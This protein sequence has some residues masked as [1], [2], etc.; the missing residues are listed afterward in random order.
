M[1]KV[2]MMSREMHSLL[3]VAVLL[4][5]QNRFILALPHGTICDD[6]SRIADDLNYEGLSEFIFTT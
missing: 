6:G 4:L 1:K 3:P 5:M 2:L